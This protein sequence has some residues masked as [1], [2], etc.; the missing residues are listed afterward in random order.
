MTMRTPNRTCL[1]DF[2]KNHYYLENVLGA[3]LLII[4]AYSGLNGSISDKKASSKIEGGVLC[5]LEAQSCT[6]H[7]IFKSFGEGTIYLDWWVVKGKS[8]CLME[9]FKSLINVYVQAVYTISCDEC[10]R[11]LV[12]AWLIREIPWQQISC[13]NV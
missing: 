2:E 8:W 5:T 10:K 1:Q 12:L 6:N 4:H 7:I 11:R 13:F 9:W 3:F